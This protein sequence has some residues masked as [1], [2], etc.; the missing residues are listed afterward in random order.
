LKKIIIELIKKT[1][2]EG[3]ASVP[4][5]TIYKEAEKI[6]KEKKINFKMDTFRNSIR[7]ELNKH[8]QNSNHPD[9]QSLFIRTSKG[10]YTLTPSGEN[11]EGR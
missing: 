5:N 10:H 9:S 6:V 1:Q 4:L 7:G 11:Y 3:R 8:E 2:G